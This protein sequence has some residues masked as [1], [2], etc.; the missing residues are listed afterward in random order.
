MNDHDLIIEF[1]KL[2]KTGV[3]R[4][5]VLSQLHTS[6]KKIKDCFTKYPEIEKEYIKATKAG[7][8]NVAKHKADKKGELLLP[9]FME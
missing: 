4:K 2:R 3:P 6:D 9:V 5:K 7:E 8:C 1:V